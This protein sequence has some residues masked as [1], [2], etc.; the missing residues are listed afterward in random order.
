MAAEAIAWHRS[1]LT[2]V[3]EV[4]TSEV[5]V[6]LGMKKHHYIVRERGKQDWFKSS[7]ESVRDVLASN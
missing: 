2:S 7:W 5:K 3:S 4:K 6:N 1:L